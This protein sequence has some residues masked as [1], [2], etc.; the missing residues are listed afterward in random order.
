MHTN[1]LPPCSVPNAAG[2]RDLPWLRGVSL[3]RALKKPQAASEQRDELPKS[4]RSHLKASPQNRTGGAQA[5][6]KPHGDILPVAG[7][8][9]ALPAPRTTAAASDLPSPPTSSPRQGPSSLQ[10]QDEMM[11]EH[12]PHSSTLVGGFH[13]GFGQA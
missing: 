2:G 12:P 1:P 8:G 9:D 11:P 10:S 3:S 4:H 7:A 5:E 13:H 6:S